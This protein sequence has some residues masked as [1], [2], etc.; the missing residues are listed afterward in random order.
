M[1]GNK[2]LTLFC[3]TLTLIV[4]Q[5]EV[6][7]S[8]LWSLPKRQGSVHRCSGD[9]QWG[10]DSREE[11]EEGRTDGVRRTKTGRTARKRQDQER[12]LENEREM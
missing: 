3:E 5:T 12:D 2:A 9:N 1:L 10:S 7:G 4:P 8:T 11:A 6:N